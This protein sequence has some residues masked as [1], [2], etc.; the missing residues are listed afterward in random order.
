M[1][2]K[3]ARRIRMGDVT[4]LNEQGELKVKLGAVGM[5]GTDYDRP[6]WSA[7]SAKDARLL[8]SQLNQWADWVDDHGRP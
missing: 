7:L 2:R 6:Y 3:Q 1:G 4:P 8:A 5:E